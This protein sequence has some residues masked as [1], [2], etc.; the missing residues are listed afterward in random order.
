MPE[1]MRS[2]RMNSRSLPSR[3]ATRRRHEKSSTAASARDG[4]TRIAASAMTSMPTATGRS[5]R[6]FRFGS[7]YEIWLEPIEKS[8]RNGSAEVV[9]TLQIS[10]EM[11]GTDDISSASEMSG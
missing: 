3:N 7:D 8:A 4:I 10:Q 9:K 2:A 5:R 11:P 1:A 6:P